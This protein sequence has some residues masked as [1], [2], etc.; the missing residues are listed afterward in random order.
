MDLTI[1]S[2]IQ[3]PL[4]RT[5]QSIPTNSANF[6]HG[7]PDNTP[8]FSK[9]QIRVKPDSGNPDNLNGVI[10]F[11][12]PQQGHLNN[13]YLVYRMYGNKSDTNEVT[14]FDSDNVF[15]FGEGIEY[16]ELRSHNNV[17]QRIYAEA[18]PFEAASVA[19]GE[20][21]LKNT[22]QGL[23]GYWG[24]DGTS[25]YQPPR[26]TS[27]TYEQTAGLAT[28]RQENVVRDFLIP[29]PL[30]STFYLKDN[31][32][33]RMLEDLHIYVKTRTS[34]TQFLGTATPTGSP[35]PVTN[36]HDLELVLDY[37]NFH[38]NVEEVIRNE[39]FKPDVPAALLQ[40]DYLKFAASY[41]RSELVGTGGKNV[42]YETK[43]NTD[44]LVTDI[45]IV[46]KV[47][48]STRPYVRPQSMRNTGFYFELRSSNEVVMSGFKGELD[49]IEA[50][51]YS[52]VTRQYQ[53][54]G[55]LPLRWASGGTRIR[56][57]LN[58]TDE[59]FDG[60]I[61]FQSLVEPTLVIR[62][63]VAVGNAFSFYVDEGANQQYTLDS[64]PELVEFDVILK[65][66]VMLRIDGNT[67]K[68]S[69]SLE[70]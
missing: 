31:F 46:P 5:L 16:V 1:H 30:S 15:N 3:S 28:G 48:P 7:I 44:A 65:R 42:Y 58:N 8:P 68:I 70:S 63:T 47:S 41:N 52:T 10:T 40:S 39:N 9:T 57:G 36:R 43:L 45:F 25:I 32:Q 61:S 4:V 26:Y 66:K 64:N 54:E 14:V 13:A 33:T 21:A 53:N 12:I 17:I 38:E 69:K 29:I 59:Y 22:L 23:S 2:Q 55:V 24:S 27:P 18:I 19:Q 20:Q 6:V 51:H 62:A 60:G 37:V 49:G 34:T 67:G 56:L 35:L 11:K 50:R